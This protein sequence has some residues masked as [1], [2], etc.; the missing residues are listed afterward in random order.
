[1]VLV[2]E[3]FIR[4]LRESRLIP[5]E[6]VAS[7][8]K[9]LQG[10]RTP[11]TVEDVAKLLV[12]SGKLTEYQAATI[13]QGRPQSLILGEYVLLNVLGKG[14]MGVVFRARHRLMD[15]VVALKTLP[16][17]VI[18]PR[19]VQRFYR[20]VKAAARLSHPNIVTAYDA[21]EHAGTHYLVME[22]VA[23]RDLAAI[24]KEKG[25]LSLRQAIDYAQQA[26]RG[27]EFAH[28][29]GVVHRDVKPS[30]LLL[31]Q[32]GV[33]KILDMGLARLNEDFGGTP[34]AME[35][36]G[37]G[38]ILGTVDYMSPEQAAEVRSA[39]HRSDIYSLGC[40][41]F[42]L[43]TRRAV[44]AGET[45]VKRILAHRD[46]PIPSV[47]ELR[48]D[49]PETLDA[50]I[51]RML[52]KRP[53]DRP[54]SMAEI[55][56]E[57]ESC[58][59][60]PDA[61]PPLVAELPERPDSVQNWLEDLGAEDATP[62][63]EDSQ[64]R[65]A[66]VRSPSKEDAPSRPLKSGAGG[67]SIRRLKPQTYRV[68]AKKSGPAGRGRNAWK[69]VAVVT[70]AAVVV[71]AAMVLIHSQGGNDTDAV[72]KDTADAQAKTGGVSADDDKNGGA[73]APPE[74]DRP[75][76]A[77]AWEEAWA[78][79]KGR[80]DNLVAQRHF[81]M[82]IQAYA[83]LAERFPDPPSRKRC[84][85]AIER[86]ESEAKAAFQRVESVASEELRPPLA[87][88]PFDEKTAKLH[89]ARWAKHLR[90]PVVQTNSIGMKLVLIPP[91]EFEMGSP[92][93]LIKEEQRSH[94]GDGWYTSRLP[95][96]MPRH[97]VRVTRPFWLAATVVTQEE[98]QQVVGVNPSEFAGNPGRPVER[99]SRDDAMTFCQRL[100]ELP[101]EKAAKRRYHLPT[102]AQWEYACRAGTATTWYFGQDQTLLGDYAWTNRNTHTTAAVGQKLPN[103]WGLFD[104]YGNVWEWC[105]DWYSL[106]KRRYDAT[107]PTNDPA[108]PLHGENGVTRG[109][110]FSYDAEFCR[111][112]YRFNLLGGSRY[113]DV[114][115]RVSLIPADK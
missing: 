8:Q 71:A 113:H 29:H 50:L 17:G 31:D 91:G 70:S 109:G 47:M 53:E 78:D 6:E 105:Q 99:V 36:T 11:H 104:M 74:S 19:T 107:S 102:E 39:D 38:Q 108:G 4:N 25:P 20:E 28:K 13:S 37:A 84:K 110:S 62:R 55:I 58:L 42:Y 45:T 51:R 49:C 112:A 57:L 101:A 72:R 3:Q 43:L 77:S 27:L 69:V 67:S 60:K 88:A 14:G 2:L 35:L 68:G 15:R 33:V 5:A 92:V 114:G 115:F 76:Q 56:V 106:N 30:N 16:A 34:E 41:L 95:G 79:T 90:V 65:E 32:E 97:T 52:A 54:Q 96:E 40:T 22:Y 1:M 26:A 82:A 64:V 75:N 12:Q 61:A 85:E 9:A 18:K 89:Q 7:L 94:A 100:S 81:A 66:T 111:S 73:D 63:A 103:A 23:G 44:Y 98:Y 59:A 86:I 46:K 93:E 24:V 21:G 87:V 80:A 10:S 83:T 48:P